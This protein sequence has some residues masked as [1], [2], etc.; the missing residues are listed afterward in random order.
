MTD[1][2]QHEGPLGTPIRAAVEG[3]GEA[4]RVAVTGAERAGERTDAAT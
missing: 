4:T 3:D 2:N 1:R